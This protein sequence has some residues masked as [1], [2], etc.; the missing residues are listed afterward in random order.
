MVVTS[1]CTSEVRRRLALADPS[2]ELAVDRSAFTSTQVFLLFLSVCCR[3]HLLTLLTQQNSPRPAL[4]TRWSLC[5]LSPTG[6]SGTPVCRPTFVHK[7]SGMFIRLPN[8]PTVTMT[9]TTGTTTPREH[10]VTSPCAL[11]P[12]S[13]SLSLTLLPLRR[14]GTTSRRVLVPPV[15]VP[16]TLS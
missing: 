12:P 6:S 10:S 14:F 2:H 13:R 4:L 3:I 5:S 1:T 9:E 8:L 15:L 7:A 11:L 16:P